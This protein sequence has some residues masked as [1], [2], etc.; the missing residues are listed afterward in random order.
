MQQMKLNFNSKACFCTNRKRQMCTATISSTNTTIFSVHWWLYSV[1]IRIKFVE[2]KV[3]EEEWN[4]FHSHQ[5]D[6]ISFSFSFNFRKMCFSRIFF[7]VKYSFSF[8]FVPFI[9]ALHGIQTDHCNFISF[10]RREFTI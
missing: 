2:G 5:S 10:I 1:F 6:E 3:H 7:F 4:F 9:S 8:L